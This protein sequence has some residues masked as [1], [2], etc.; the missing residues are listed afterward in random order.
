MILNFI[1]YEIISSI[2]PL[3]TY[4]FGAFAWLVPLNAKTLLLLKL[5]TSTFAWYRDCWVFTEVW[6]RLPGKPWQTG[7]T[8]HIKT[9]DAMHYGVFICL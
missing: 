6:C 2:E 7:S 9:V 5:H 3:L 8:M 1:K 4:K